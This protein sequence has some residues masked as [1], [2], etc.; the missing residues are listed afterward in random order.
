MTRAL[1]LALAWT[2][3]SSTLAS[4]GPPR[5]VDPARLEALVD[6]AVEQALV[7]DGIAGVGVAVVDASGVLLAKGYGQ[8]APDQPADDATLFRVGS[9]SKTAVWIALMQLVE[10]G[11]LSL[12]DPVNDHLP[13]ALRI[14]DEGFAEP[15]RVRHLMTHSAGFEDSLLGSLFASDPARLQPMPEYLASHR[16]HRVRPPGQLAAYSNYGAALA[17]AIVAE[18][19][20]LGWEDYAEQRVLRPLGMATAT[21]REPYPAELAAARGLPAPMPADVAAR[22][23]AGWSVEAGRAKPETTEFVEQLAPAGALSAS[24]RD[25]AAYM[26]ALLDPARMEQAGVLRAATALEMREP[27][28]ANTPGFGPLRHGFLDYRLPG[29]PLAF[30]HDGGLIFQHARM[31]VSPDLGIGI[32]LAINSSAGSALHENLPLLIVREFFG[33]AAPKGVYGA[34]AAADADALSGTYLGLR[35][36]YFRTERA[37]MGMVGAVQIRATDAGDLLVPSFGSQPPRRFLPL[38]DGRYVSENGGTEVAFATRDGRAMLF[39]SFGMMPMERLGFLERPIVGLALLGAAHLVVLAG[40]VGIARR[41]W[42]GR[43]GSRALDAVTLVWTVAIALFWIGLAPLAGGPAAAVYRYPGAVFPL[44]CWAL[45]LA[46]AVTL[47]GVAALPGAARAAAAPRRAWLAHGGSL[48][49]LLLS[50]LALWRMGLLG[51]SGW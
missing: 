13:P 27:L 24:A 46:A 40:L 9:I 20:G 16:V 11:K 47:L 43:P 18:V 29:K 26:R 44:G 35:R 15:I 14:P 22:L 7:Q 28:F 39:E 37:L 34:T 17:G 33:G 38:G 41:W 50:S 5:P 10:Q 6:G 4:A 3:V 25:M 45:A 19:S 12:D 1:R 42:R 31:I 23:S 21:Y 8:A 49:V 32:F 51:Y 30:G 48:A 36:P 2:L